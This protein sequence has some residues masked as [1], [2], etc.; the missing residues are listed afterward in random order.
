MRK[1]KA[2]KLI[3]MAAWGSAD[4]SPENSS[5]I[6]V[7]DTETTGLDP[8]ESEIIQ[9][10]VIDGDGNTLI[11]SYVKP[12]WSKEWPEAAAVNG[13]TPETVKDAPYA[14]ELIP[15]VR[16][17]FE[18]ADLWIAY[19]NP[20]DLSFLRFWGIDPTGKKQVDVMREFAPVYGEWNEEKGSYK[21]QK[22]TKAAAY[23][24]YS[25]SAHDSLEDVK[26]TLFVYQKMKE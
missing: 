1:D 11:N 12:Y 8:E 9:I 4:P 20:F 26:A 25:F 6:I 10:S 3:K 22:L 19:N 24:G 18:G 15:K 14:H 17:I 16:G 23:Y 5:G 2:K 13:I 7:F 21:W